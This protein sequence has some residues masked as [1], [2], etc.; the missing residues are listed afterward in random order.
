M[1]HHDDVPLILSRRFGGV[2]EHQADILLVDDDF[3]VLRMTDRTLRSAGYSTIRAHCPTAAM[4]VLDTTR[5]SLLILDVNMPLLNGIELAAGVRRGEFACAN[6]DVPIL[7]LTSDD[8]ESTYEDT[9]DVGAYGFLLKPID[10]AR[11]LDAVQS[12]LHGPVSSFA[13]AT[14]LRAVGG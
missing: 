3:D 7:F 14:P 4:E 2:C 10:P 5:F 1:V 13:R 6:R 9:F 11:L 12:T 8:R